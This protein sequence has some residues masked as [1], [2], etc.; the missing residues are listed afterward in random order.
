MVQARVLRASPCRTSPWRNMQDAQKRHGTWGF[1]KMVGFPNKTIGF[2]DL[3]WSFWGVLGVPPF[4]ET[5][6]WGS[7]MIVCMNPNLPY[8]QKTLSYRW[9][10]FQ[11]TVIC[12]G[13]WTWFEYVSNGLKPNSNSSALNKSHFAE[14]RKSS[15]HFC[16]SIFELRQQSKWSAIIQDNSIFMALLLRIHI[17]CLP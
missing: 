8:P 16:V 13:R 7:V 15:K 9:W 4:Q 14:R 2:S 6:T 12:W 3:K 11:D 17:L 1:P 10:N 5:P